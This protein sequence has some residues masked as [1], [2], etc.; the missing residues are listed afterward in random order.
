MARVWNLA[1]GRVVFGLIEIFAE[2]LKISG[3]SK[4]EFVNFAL[5]SCI[6]GKWLFANMSASALIFFILPDNNHEGE[7]EHASVCFEKKIKRAIAGLLF[8][9]YLFLA[10]S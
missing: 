4:F 10:Q 3:K 8:L 9:G 1:S 5:L 7:C 6:S 2:F